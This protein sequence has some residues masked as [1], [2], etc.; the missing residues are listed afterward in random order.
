MAKKQG[1]A[2]V[3]IVIAALFAVS[4]LHLF[5][6]KAYQSP[7]SATQKAAVSQTA[8]EGEEEAEFKSSE[9]DITEEQNSLWVLFDNLKFGRK[10]LQPKVSFYA[11]ILIL[12]IILI[13]PAAYFI[14]KSADKMEWLWI[15]I[16]AFALGFTFLIL[17]SNS[18][19]KVV[20][21]VVDSLTVLSP[22]QNDVV[23]VAST[24]PG[25][26]SYEL[27]FGE[28]IKEIHPLYMGGEYELYGDELIQKSRPYTILKDEDQITL[29]LNPQSAFTRDYFRLDLN[30]KEK[31]NFQVQTFLVG[32]LPEGTITNE[33]GYDFSYVLV[34]Y[35]EQFCIFQGVAKG[36][37]ISL[38][39]KQWHSI[40]SSDF[41]K[42]ADRTG[43][44]SDMKQLMM[45]AYE[46]Y[47]MDSGDNKIHLTGVLSG[48]DGVIDKD[49]KDLV[50]KG[51]FYQMADLKEE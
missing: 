21:P 15:Y 9:E 48:Y 47:Y 14:L 30:Q 22:D 6:S 34:Y 16:P 35:Q 12:Y 40:Y 19:T 39:K 45:F 18:N 29:C 11:V 51:I 38:D 8:V 20:N 2:V 41:N 7:P 10:E 43:T 5:N 27:V 49:K 26:K 42:L 3:L 17:V 31:G 28:K 1:K 46:K 13:G 23:Y 24:S 25:K 36:G 33:T 4:M 50:S 44:K 37:R 32:E